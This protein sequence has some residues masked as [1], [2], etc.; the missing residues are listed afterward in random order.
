[1]SMVRR[2]FIRRAGL[3]FSF[4]LAGGARM[5]L[6]PAQAR[7]RAAPFTVLSDAEAAVLEAVAE[8]LLPGAA[9]AGVAHFADSQLDID[10]NDSLLALK[11]FN[12]PPPYAEFYQAALR[13]ITALARRR[14]G[15]APTALPAAA[16][17]G[18]VESLRDNAADGWGG[19][20]PPLVYHA[21]RN[22]AVD[23]VYGGAEGFKKL[24]APYRPHV[25]PPE[26][27]RHGRS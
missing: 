1:M 16:G 5:L 7:A 18:L 25:T 9:A 3:A 24:G 4:T 27:W 13:E 23:V 10:A 14:H 19:P 22:D 12:Y 21:L 6:T 26:D 17:R 20:P 11:Y 2:D 8:I 15:S